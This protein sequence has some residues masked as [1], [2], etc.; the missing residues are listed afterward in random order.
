[1]ASYYDQKK[2]RRMEYG[3]VPIWESLDQWSQSKEA[4][5]KNYIIFTCHFVVPRA[6]ARSRLWYSIEVRSFW[7]EGSPWTRLC[8]CNSIRKTDSILKF[9]HKVYI[10]IYHQIN[11]DI[12]YFFIS[13]QQGFIH[14]CYNR[15]NLNYKIQASNQQLSNACCPNP[16]F[17]TI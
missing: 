7:S 6:V 9:Q 14:T 1:M 13:Y 17:N 4:S 10:S 15:T 3:D 5:W 12:P 8:S 16:T 2:G 11:Y